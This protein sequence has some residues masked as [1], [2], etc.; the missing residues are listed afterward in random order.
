MVYGSRAV[1]W[2]DVVSVALAIPPPSSLSRSSPSLC[3]PSG[4]LAGA[5]AHCS[6]RLPQL[7]GLVAAAGMSFAP[8]SRSSL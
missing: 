7:A 8:F 3:P 2:S 6:L 1:E 4:Q 5:L